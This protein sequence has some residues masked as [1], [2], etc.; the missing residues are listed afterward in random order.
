MLHLCPMPSFQSGRQIL[1]MVG[2][3]L[4]GVLGLPPHRELGDVDHHPAAPLPATVG[5]SERTRGAL[6]SSDD[7]GSR[8]ERMARRQVSWRGMPVAVGSDAEWAAV[9]SVS[10]LARIHK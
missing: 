6:L 9:G 3:Q 7:Y 8:L 5:A 4:A 1:L 10:H 2:G